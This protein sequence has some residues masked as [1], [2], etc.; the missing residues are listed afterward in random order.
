MGVTRRISCP[1][2]IPTWREV[3]SR[4]TAG[5]VAVEMRMIDGQ[6]AFPDEEPPDDWQE[7]RVSVGGWMVTIRR[8]GSAVELIRWGDPSAELDRAVSLLERALAD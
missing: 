5:G 2:G 1:R 3:K 4:L 8:D 7:L 6:L